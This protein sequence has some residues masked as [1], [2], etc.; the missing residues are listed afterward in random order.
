MRDRPLDR[1]TSM[2]VFVRTAQAGSLSAAAQA[3][4][5][6]K[7]TVSKHLSALEEHLGVLL[8]NRTTR[9][10][11]LTELGVAY[12]DHAQRILAEIEETELAIQEHTVEPKGR[13]RINAPM[14]FGI[15]HIAPLLPGFMTA[16]P[17]VE[18]ELVLDDRRVDL[19]EE[20][21]DLAIRIGR[22]DDSTLI[23]RRL[24]AVHFI[25]AAADSYLARRRPITRPED[26]AGHNCL[27]YSLNRQPS[28]WRFDRAG[29]GLAVKVA[30][31][32]TANNGEA[33]REAAVSGLGVVF[34]PAFIVGADIASGRLVPLLTDWGTPVIDIHAVFPEQRRLQPK[35]RRFVDYMATELRRPGL[36]PE[37]PRPVADLADGR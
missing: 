17:R 7:S 10:L 20:G 31:T 32:L 34:Q 9:R 18:V 29:E 22:L 4:G 35:L 37:M 14:S 25:C 8:M 6:S 36:W 12:R 24:A 19:I 30:G 26:L 3:M 13:L 21:Y 16:H 1:I 5:L 15:G 33:L 27:R 2:A 23:A 28:E 11:S